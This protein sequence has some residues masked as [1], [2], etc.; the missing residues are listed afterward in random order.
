MVRRMTSLTKEEK[1]TNSD[2]WQ[3][4]HRVQYHLNTCIIHLLNRAHEHDQSKLSSPEVELFTEYT[5][6]L[7]STTFGSEEYNQYKKE[8]KVALDHHYANNRHHIEFH[9][10]GIEDMNL[11]DLIELLVDWTAASE[12]HNNGNINHSLDINIEKYNISNQLAK[13]LRN[14]LHLLR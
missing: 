2:T 8:M 9:K 10:N 14:T 7:A 12:R 5:S 11:I 6:K 13:I 4:I 3:H 1:A